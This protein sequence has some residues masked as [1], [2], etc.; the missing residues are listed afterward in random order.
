MDIFQQ[1]VLRDE[2]VSRT[3]TESL[4]TLIELE[5]CGR[6]LASSLHPLRLV[7][8][9]SIS[10]AACL[11]FSRRRQGWRLHFEAVVEV[12]PPILAHDLFRLVFGDHRASSVSSDAA[13]AAT[14]IGPLCRPS[15]QVDPGLLLSRSQHSRRS[16]RNGTG[17]LP[18]ENPREDRARRR[19]VRSGFRHC[20]FDVSSVCLDVDCDR[21]Q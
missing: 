6:R 18:Q 16:A 8:L 20:Q 19:E 21:W 7:Y 14:R 4:L 17:Q 12:F 15:A 1:T 2:V 3:V 10:R 9:I 13:A 11:S 5:R